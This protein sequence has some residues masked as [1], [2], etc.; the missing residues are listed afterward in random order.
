MTGSAVTACSARPSVDDL[1]DRLR[2]DRETFR[3]ILGDRDGLLAKMCRYAKFRAEQEHLPAWSIVGEIT[4]HG[5]GVSSA[6]YELYRD[7]S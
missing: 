3:A 2:G 1:I 6:I 7:R 5:S 4:G